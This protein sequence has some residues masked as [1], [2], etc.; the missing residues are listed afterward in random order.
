MDFA[1]QN[2]TAGQLN[3]IVKKLGGEEGALRFLRGELLVSAAKPLEMP[4]WKTVKLGL[5]KSPDDYRAAIK[6]AK[7]KIGDWGDDILGRITCS[8]EETEVDLVV[9]SVGD[10]GFKDGARYADICAKAVEL[11]L[12][13]CPAE[14]GPA[15]RLQYPDQPRGEWVLVAIE[16]I[17]DR[18]GDRN[19]FDVAHVSGELWLRGDSGHPDSFW[20]ADDRFAFVRRK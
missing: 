15:L 6:K 18:Y 10:L 16:A 4:V 3:A 9:L 20:V 5:H 2:L 8:Q 14:V 12:E 13:L 11:G 19:I 17:T 1:S 7:Q